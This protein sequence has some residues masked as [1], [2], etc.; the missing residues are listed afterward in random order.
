M[1]ERRVWNPSP[2]KR[3]ALDREQ[4]EKRQAK[5]VR[6]LRDVADDPDLADEIEGLSIPEY[7]ER[8]G[9]GLLN[10]PIKKQKG[11]PMK[12]D[13]LK[14]AVRDGMADALKGVKEIF[15]DTRRNPNGQQP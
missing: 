10:N 6:F 5:A 11:K 8:K 12:K 9:F 1:A 2:R 14:E 15:S 4:V 3:K 7:A 13:E